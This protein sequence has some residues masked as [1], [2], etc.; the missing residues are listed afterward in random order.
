MHEYVLDAPMWVAAVILIL[1]F[2]GI[3]TEQ[4]HGFERAKFAMAGAG[5]MLLVGQYMGFYTP[6]EAIHAI[7]W[8]VIF[9]LGCMMAIVAI[10]IPTGGFEHLAYKMA[11]MSRG[12]LY[13]LLVLLG[14]AVTLLSL[15]LDNVTT[16]VIF[17]PLII[18]IAQRLGVSPVPYLMAAALLSDT[19]GVATLVGDPP[20][21]MIGS[22]AG[23][24]FNTFLIHMGG[25]V[26][27]AWLVI[28]LILRWLFK[29][30]LAAPV[31]GSFTETHQLKNP[32]IWYA[33]LGIMGMMVVLF[34]LH[35]TLGWEPWMISA[36]GLTIL[37]FIARHVELEHTMEHV[38]VPLLV[39][40]ISLF[41]M[42]GGVEKSHFLHWVGQFIQPLVEH[43]LLMATLALLWVSAILSALIDNIPFT[44]AMIPILMGL[45]QHGANVTP[46]WW[47][48]AAGVGMGGNGTHVGST[49]NVFI[50]TISE[51]LAKQTGNPDYAITAGVWARKGLPAMLVSLLACTVGILAF[52]EFFSAP[53]H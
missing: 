40:F 29:T 15:L 21:L 53:I 7:D 34:T 31:T 2:A 26:F 33:S 13:L 18:M 52:F 38:E 45:E 6:E 46:L 36:L 9:L 41:I 25:L 37:L 47:A 51:R 48:L 12:R 23:I 44:A 22:A 50:V 32:R 3:F 5:A 11:A 1:T 8:N 20:N 28:I 10:M 4:L 39:F 30:E 16:V 19:G 42:I 49:A 43:N 27:F 14:T 35:E 17:G 24:D